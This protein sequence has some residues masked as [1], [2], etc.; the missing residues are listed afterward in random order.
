VG[1]TLSE[2]CPLPGGRPSLP[3]PRSFA[4]GDERDVAGLLPAGALQQLLDAAPTA[5]ARRDVWRIAEHL[6]CL[7]AAGALRANTLKALAAGELLPAAPAG[8]AP[9]RGGRGG[10]SS[11]GAD[12]DAPARREELRAILACLAAAPSG[13]KLSAM[14]AAAL[15]LPWGPEPGVAPA[16]GERAAGGADEAAAEGEGDDEDVEC[17][18]CGKARPDHNLLLCDGCDAAY[19][20][21]C[22]KPAL[23]AVPEGEWFCPGCD[24]EIRGSRLG[25]EAAME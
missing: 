3:Q 4:P 14:L 10:A 8:A 12:A 19:H 22:L 20:T 17:R 24:A 2:P 1:D 25:A 6:P 16:G 23:K 11:S 21:T 15:G 13:P 18:R 7:E 5:A 9:A